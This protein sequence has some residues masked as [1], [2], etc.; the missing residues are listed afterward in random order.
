MLIL[1]RVGVEDVLRWPA[2][3]HDHH[4]DDES[5][6]LDDRAQ[7]LF[8]RVAVGL[9]RL[10]HHIADVDAQRPRMAQRLGDLFDDKV[11]QHGRVQ[12]AGSDEDHVGVR[13]LVECALHRR[14]V[15]RIDGEAHD[16]CMARLVAHLFAEV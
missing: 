15:G 16:A 10:R 12:R 3:V 6:V 1:F 8:G 2:P 7:V 4:I 5:R 13:E 9:A 14:G 11:R